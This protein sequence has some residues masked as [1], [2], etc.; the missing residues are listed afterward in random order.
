MNTYKGH[1][2]NEKWYQVTLNGQP[3]DL[4]PSLKLHSYSP[5]GFSWSYAGSGPAQL[6][7]AILLH[8]AGPEVARSHDA[9][10]MSVIAALPREGWTLTSEDVDAWL[11]KR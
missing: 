11:T 2:D 4:A 3:F 7:L 5:D 10:Y 9:D 6:A 8:E 1:F